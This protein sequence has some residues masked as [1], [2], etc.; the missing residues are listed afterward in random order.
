[1]NISVDFLRNNSSNHSRFSFCYADLI[2]TL[3]PTDRAC[4]MC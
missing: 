3:F 4:D 2:N 1:M